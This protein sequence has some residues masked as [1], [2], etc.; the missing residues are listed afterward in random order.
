MHIPMILQSKLTAKK[1]YNC[2][3]NKH[4]KLPL[5]NLKLMLKLMSIIWAIRLLIIYAFNNKGGI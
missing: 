2:I 5:Q 4:V 3:I 1:I